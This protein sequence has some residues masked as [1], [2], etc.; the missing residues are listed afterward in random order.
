MQC[1]PGKRRGAIFNIKFIEYAIGIKTIFEI[2]RNKKD[3][4]CLS[5]L[6][7]EAITWHQQ[8]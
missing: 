2:V 6:L 3:R 1:E 8:P 4:Q 7:A 5:F